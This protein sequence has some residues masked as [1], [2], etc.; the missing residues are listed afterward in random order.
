M[1]PFGNISGVSLNIM[2]PCGGHVFFQKP[3][4]RKPD[5]PQTSLGA[6]PLVKPLTTW[7]V[8]YLE[9]LGHGFC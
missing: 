7:A 8:H 2:E 9:Y 3:S 5:N 1:S 6:V 4:A